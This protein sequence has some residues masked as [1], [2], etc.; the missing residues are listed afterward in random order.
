LRGDEISFFYED[1]HDEVHRLYQ[2]SEAIGD[3]KL[4]HDNHSELELAV[5]YILLCIDRFI[6]PAYQ[7]KV[8]ARSVARRYFRVL[9]AR[10]ELSRETIAVMVF[11]LM[12]TVHKYTKKEINAAIDAVREVDNA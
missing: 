6:E 3:D 7:K 10:P 11:D 1:M 12:E 5:D 2:L 8:R 4:T 9:S